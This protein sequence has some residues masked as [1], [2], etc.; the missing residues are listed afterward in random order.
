MGEE[1]LQNTELFFIETTE[2]VADCKVVNGQQLGPYNTDFNNRFLLLKDLGSDNFTVL[3]H[4]DFPKFNQDKLLSFFI[5]N[6]SNL[7]IYIE[8]LMDIMLEINKWFDLTGNE[9]IVDSK[10]FRMVPKI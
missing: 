4:G 2:K 10:R 7:D 8:S 5:F 3:D 6:N 9:I 1:M